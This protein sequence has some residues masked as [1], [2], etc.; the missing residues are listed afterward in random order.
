MPK[1]VIKKETVKDNLGDFLIALTEL[2]K[3]LTE[4]VKRE[5]ENERR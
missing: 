4:A 1:K 5:L 2:V 3:V